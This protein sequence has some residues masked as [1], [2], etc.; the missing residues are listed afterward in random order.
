MFNI[1]RWRR[2][3]TETEIRLPR[4][5]DDHEKS[6]SELK[7][8]GFTDSPHEASFTLPESLRK[9]YKLSRVAFQLLG[10]VKEGEH[11][12]Y[13]SIVPDLRRPLSPRDP[14]PVSN[15]L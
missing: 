7:Q 8:N 4:H 2:H 9:T 1:S 10:V 13:I 14:A 3:I 15:I 5:A 12:F 11:R 6:P